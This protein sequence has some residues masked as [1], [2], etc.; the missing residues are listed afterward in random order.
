MPDAW[1]AKE[2]SPVQGFVRRACGAAPG[3]AFVAS[4]GRDAQKVLAMRR[5]DPGGVQV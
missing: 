1:R 3:K 2:N 5:P 4:P